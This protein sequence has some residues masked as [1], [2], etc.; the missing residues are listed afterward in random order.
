MIS[1]AD[2]FRKIPFDAGKPKTPIEVYQA[3]AKVLT[4]SLNINKAYES[5]TG[6]SEESVKYIAAAY[7]SLARLHRSLYFEKNHDMSEFV[8]AAHYAHLSLQKDSDLDLKIIISPPGSENTV[9]DICDRGN[10]QAITPQYAN[11]R[12][13][14]SGMPDPRVKTGKIKGI[15]SLG[16]NIKL[17]LEEKYTG[18]GDDFPISKWQEPELILA[19]YYLLTNNLPDAVGAINKVRKAAG[20]PKFHS[21]D[22]QRIKKQIIYARKAE[23][24]LEFRRWQDMRYYNIIPKRWKPAAVKRGLI[25][26]SLSHCARNWQILTFDIGVI[27]G[28]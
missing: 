12:D 25:G 3:A 8:K 17:F 20:L 4:K 6:G 18:L 13:P 5:R 16:G 11:L 1:E 10:Y 24:W 9:Y 28:Y 22:P 15:S 14:V 21:S 19:E 2:I 26:D 7:A 27:K 23:F